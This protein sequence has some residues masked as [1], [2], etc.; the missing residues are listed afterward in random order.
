MIDSQPV[1]IQK[2]SVVTKNFRI[3]F[4]QCFS[5][6]IDSQ[7][8]KIQKCFFKGAKTSRGFLGNNFLSKMIDS[9]ESGLVG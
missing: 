4:K 3:I 5:K 2:N 7:C 6:M 1:K 8:I 9:G